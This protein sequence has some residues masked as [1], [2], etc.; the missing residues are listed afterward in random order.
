MHAA[1]GYGGGANGSVL[2]AG[3]IG[4]TAAEGT[5]NTDITLTMDD[6]GAG[7]NVAN[8][9]AANTGFETA[10]LLEATF[11]GG[12]GP[13]S[14]PGGDYDYDGTKSCF[15]QTFTNGIED[16]EIDV[17]SLVEQWLNS[18]GN[19]YGAKSSARYGIGLFLTGTQEG[20][21]DGTDESNGRLH[22]PTGSARSYY[23]KKFFARGSE[24]FF[25]RPIIEARWDSADKDNRGNLYYSSSLAPA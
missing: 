12:D 16:L 4:L 6:V 17:T 20:F 9:L 15:E 24:F 14:R 18:A 5:S 3:T 19:T 11:T 1:V 23:T 7:G 13:W 25:K 8:V 21:Y 2:A 22:N 10:L